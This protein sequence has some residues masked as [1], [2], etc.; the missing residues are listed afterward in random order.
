[1]AALVVFASFVLCAP[2]WAGNASASPTRHAPK[3]H[4]SVSPGTLTYLGGRVTVKWSSAHAT[5]CTLTASPRFW[6]GRDSKHVKCHGRIRPV[7]AAAA[8]PLRWQFTLRAK[9]AKGQVA[10]VR[11]KLVVHAP[12]FA[13]SPNWSGYVVPSTTPVTSVSGQFTVPKLNCKHTPNAGESTWAGIGG[14]GASSGD[15]LQTGV[16]SDCEGGAQRNDAAW[17]E[18][19]PQKPEIDFNTMSVSPGDSMR[20]SVVQNPGGSWTTRLDDL[21]T[22]IS[23]VMTTG[24]SFGTVLDSSPTV[25]LHEEGSAAAVSYAGGYTAEWIVEAFEFSNGFLVQL[26]DFGK[27]TFTGLTTSVPGWKLTGAEQVGIGDEG[28]YLY[29]APSRPDSSGRGFS[30]SYVG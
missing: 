10:V 3:A 17:W 21:T 8:L 25:W 27:V 16:R 22:G 6:A 12:P 24:Q 1:V 7:I 26:A 11:R 28:G 23:G 2:A 29:D 4:L 20:A 13:V 19:Y 15:L 5:R 14:A 30:V 18:E 9:N